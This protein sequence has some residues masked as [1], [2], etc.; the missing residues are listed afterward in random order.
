MTF[1]Q[2]HQKRRWKQRMNFSQM[3][4]NRG[5]PAWSHREHFSCQDTSASW[6]K[7]ATTCFGIYRFASKAS[8]FFFIEE[9]AIDDKFR[10]RLVDVL[11]RWW[12]FVYK[13]C[14]WSLSGF[15]YITV[16][17]E[18]RAPG[19]PSVLG[20]LLLFACISS[21]TEAAFDPESFREWIA[22]SRVVKCGKR[23]PGEWF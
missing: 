12:G 18:T 2:F 10:R 21:R 14:K 17:M 20:I 23:M 13:R 16:P 9:E 1:F 5:N 19:F 3:S 8:R 11:N 22:V 15:L 6:R 7:S 4:E